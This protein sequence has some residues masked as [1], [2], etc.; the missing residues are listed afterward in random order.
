MDSLDIEPG[1]VDGWEAVRVV[2]N[3]DRHED[4]LMSLT[5][6]NTI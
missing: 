2:G 6:S 1:T 3:G 5:L 4:Y